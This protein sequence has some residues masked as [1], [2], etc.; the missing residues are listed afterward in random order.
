MYDIRDD[1]IHSTSWGQR[2]EQAERGGARDLIS[3]DRLGRWTLGCASP[4]G[5]LL[6]TLRRE[7]VSHVHEGTPLRVKLSLAKPDAPRG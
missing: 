3:G 7:S 5:W 2:H 1:L 6:L 4:S